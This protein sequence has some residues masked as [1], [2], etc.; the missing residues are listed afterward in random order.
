[1]EKTKLVIFGAT[2][3]LT[4]RKL[5]PALY[6]LEAV[7]L[8]PEDMKVISVGRREIDSDIY[9]EKAL[10]AIKSFSRNEPDLDIWKRLC[11]KIEYLKMDFTKQEE[12][13]KLS[14]IYADTKQTIFYLAVAPEYFETITLNL[15][16]LLKEFPLPPRV[17]I[18]KPFGYD[19]NS[20][21]LLNNLL[22]ETYGEENIYRI[23]HYLGKEM[24]QNIMFI[25]FGNTIFE[26]IWNRDY[27]EQ[28]QII[29]SETIGIETRGNYYERAGAIR[30]MLQ[31][32]LLQLV[33][34]IAMDRPKDL[35]TETIRDEK[36]KVLSA[37]RPQTEAE[38]KDYLV[39]G[40][41]GRLDD[42]PAYR[43]E[44][45]VSP[46]SNTETFVALRLLLNSER[47]QGVPFYI[48]TGKRLP[49]KKTEI[50]IQFKKLPS[51]YNDEDLKNNQL[52]FKIQPEE[53]VYFEFNAKKPGTLEEIVPV[54]MDFCQNCEVGINSPE[55]YERLLLDVIKGDATLFTR[56]DEVEH[57]WRF[58]ESIITARKGLREFPNYL[59]FTW[60]PEAAKTMIA[61]DNKVWLNLEEKHE[62]L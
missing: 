54:K 27:I 9:K 11:E 43:E 52:V 60:G 49:V 41:Y 36:V 24:L 22:V 23:D 45:N 8:L 32:H 12:Y 57:S 30:D 35:K 56:W 59:P 34:L 33:S 42:I 10:D 2:G 58:V 1:M 39:F 53:G 62:N 29:S 44:K 47:W 46:D 25:R 61:R 55:A 37:L 7:N 17:V 50:I 20:A 16:P 3:D 31:S 51:P 18:E 13:H 4:K 21:I 26:P 19:L 15:K 38:Q 40:Q 6:N 5:L 28:I 48:M 14:N